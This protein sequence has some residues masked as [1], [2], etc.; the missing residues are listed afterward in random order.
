MTKNL[1]HEGLPTE[2][3]MDELWSCSWEPETDTKLNFYEKVKEIRGDTIIEA[4]IMIKDKAHLLLI[5]TEH[6]DISIHKKSA[7]TYTQD[8]EWVIDFRTLNES[9]QWITVELIRILSRY[10]ITISKI[11][12]LTP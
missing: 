4:K 11:S 2:K 12:F 5:D 8:D 1:L 6:Q 10:A 7:G 3:L 9:D